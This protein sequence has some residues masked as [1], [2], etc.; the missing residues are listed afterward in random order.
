LEWEQK[1]SYLCP[2]YATKTKDLKA[3]EKRLIFFSKS[4]S[5]QKEL[6]LLHP[7]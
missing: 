4:L 5:N 7:L 3:R 2:P 6:L 1:D